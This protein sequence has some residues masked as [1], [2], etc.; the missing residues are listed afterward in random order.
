[1]AA[2]GGN[3]TKGWLL[4]I[5]VS[6]L[7]ATCGYLVAQATQRTERV[8]SQVQVNAE[9][10]TRVEANQSAVLTRLDRIERKIDDAA[11]AARRRGY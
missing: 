11:T 5:V 9:R 2:D 4:G 6:L 8:E 3:I 7:T 1:M 10:L